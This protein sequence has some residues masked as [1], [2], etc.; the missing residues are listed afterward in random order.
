VRSLVGISQVAPGVHFVEGPASNW[1]VLS[2]DGTA[3]LIDAGY[4]GDFDLVTS[5]LRDVAG[6]A[7]LATIAVTHGHSDHIGSIRRLLEQDP[8]TSVVAL[9]AEL[10]N[11]RRQVTY[12]VGALDVLPHLYHARFGRWMLHA[13]RAGGLGEVGVEPVEAVTAGAALTLSGQRVVPEWTP[14]H[15]PGHAAYL[16]PE[17]GAVATGDALVT[18]HPVSTAAGPQLLHPMYHHDVP[19]ATGTF[20]EA[21]DR[22]SRLTLLPGHGP[23]LRAARG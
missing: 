8:E 6:D 7:R 10:P 18:G 12:Q 19:G 16:L 15:T 2:G 5:T 9:A 23:L 14:G 20:V 1:V 22:W 3:S 13:I 17:H 21:A 4:P 11:I